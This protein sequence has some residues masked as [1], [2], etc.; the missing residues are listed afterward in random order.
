MTDKFAVPTAGAAVQAIVQ[1]ERQIK[2]Q[3]AAGVSQ[4]EFLRTLSA[5][6]SGHP[7]LRGSYDA[8]EIEAILRS[9]LA[10]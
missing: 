2:L 5:E 1:V 7:A 9:K 6:A 10:A 4:E 8:Y 3:P